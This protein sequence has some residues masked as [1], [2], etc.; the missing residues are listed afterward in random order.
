MATKTPEAHA[1]HVA[2][3][4]RCG[5]LAAAVLVTLAAAAPAAQAG[6]VDTL[7]RQGVALRRQGKDREALEV[8]ERAAQ[9]RRTPRAAAQIGLTE[10]AL[11]LWVKAEEHIKEATAATDDAWIRKNRATLDGSLATIQE[12]LATIEVWGERPAGA[13]VLINGELAGTLPATGN[14]RVAIGT[15]TLTVRADGHVESTRTLELKKGDSVREHVTLEAVPRPRP[16][17]RLALQ[18]PADAA[19]ATVVQ[20]PVEAQPQA[21]VA[22]ERPPVYGRWWF[23]TIVGAAVIGGAATGYVLTRPSSCPTETCL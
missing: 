8:F 22:E 10:Q 1:T 19:D 18:S 14:I 2:L 23:W 16:R 7:I 13:E 11:G 5:A 21:P 20:Q 9:I 6:D 4:R 17:R 3:R 12:R 15:V